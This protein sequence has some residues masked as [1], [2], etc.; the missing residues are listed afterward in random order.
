[1]IGTPITFRR[2]KST[3]PRGIVFGADGSG[4]G[5]DPYAGQ[6]Y[7]DSGVTDLARQYY[8]NALGYV[9]SQNGP[10]TPQAQ[11]DAL[12][13]Y[14][15]ARANLAKGINLRYPWPNGAPLTGDV[16]N[17]LAATAGLP[18]AFVDSPAAVAP[19][20]PSQNVFNQI[21][22]AASDAAQ[23][24]GAE[25]K[26]VASTTTAVVSDIGK[27][28]V[29]AAMKAAGAG[30]TKAATI[31]TA[32]AKTEVKDVGAVATNVVTNVGEDVTHIGNAIADAAK[33]VA[34]DVAG[35]LATLKA[36]VNGLSPAK[37]A[38]LIQKDLGAF[39]ATFDKAFGFS[40]TKSAD[41]KGSSITSGSNAIDFSS[42]PIPKSGAVSLPFAP[43]VRGTTIYWK[44]ARKSA[45]GILYYLAALT[46]VDSLH[47]I[48][49]FEQF[50][51]S[52]FTKVENLFG[53]KHA[54]GDF[55]VEPVSGAAGAVA[56]NS[57]GAATLATIIPV[58][59]AVITLATLIIKTFAAPKGASP[60]IPPGYHLG[61]DGQVVPNVAPGS[62]GSLGPPG[63]P[64]GAPYPPGSVVGANG[65]PSDV[66]GNP[67][68]S[69]GQ[70]LAASGGV[71]HSSNAVTYAVV[72]LLF[73]VGLGLVFILGQKPKHAAK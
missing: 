27:G 15:D 53:I 10:S 51:G 24:A 61:P 65:L 48:K 34:N 5:S 18:L 14:A 21:A 66:N 38:A 22:K 32:A 70:P 49:L 30:A 2:T 57:G 25:A 17:Q 9:R 29:G 59:L 71:G 35:A 13:Q 43:S 50:L 7:A 37:A 52:E 60:P 41:A 40:P 31:A 58:V 36:L 6:R 55:G 63:T 67:L 39:Q 16:I 62:P 20:T 45:G 68:G 73:A 33:D 54:E 19:G 12:H 23:A 46:A 26:N 56:A 3:P 28:N 44:D 8:D 72:A 42:I 4:I 64:L 69:D 47:A 1:M 11:M